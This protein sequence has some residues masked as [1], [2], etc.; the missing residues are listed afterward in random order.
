MA[1][2]L[3]VCCG[4]ACLLSAW[5]WRQEVQSTT[6]HAAFIQSL[7]AIIH[8]HANVMCGMLASS[9]VTALWLWSPSLP[10]HSIPPGLDLLSHCFQTPLWACQDP[11][12]R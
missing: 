2:R 11:P 4:T 8:K 9:S 3:A 1:Q 6:A 7:P 5:Q 12:L 10:T